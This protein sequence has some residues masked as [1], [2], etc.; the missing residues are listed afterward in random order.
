[1]VICGLR[2]LG[3]FHVRVLALC[4]W[5][6]RVR[7]SFETAKATTLTTVSVSILMDPLSFQTELSLP[8]L[9][10]LPWLLLHS[11]NFN[12]ISSSFWVRWVVEDSTL[13]YSTLLSLPQECHDTRVE[14]REG[15]V[16]WVWK[17][18]VDLK[19]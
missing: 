13:F 5:V 18:M 17:W 12:P 16:L 9:F 4:P 6:L 15:F 8:L 1:M 2:V 19:T 3:W 14:D 10:P 7:R 11:S